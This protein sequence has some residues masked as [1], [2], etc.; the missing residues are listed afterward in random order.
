MGAT[1]DLNVYW[2]GED[3]AADGVKNREF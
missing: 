3:Y 2:T 1:N